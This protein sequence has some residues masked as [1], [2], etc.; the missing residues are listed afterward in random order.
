M[1][2]KG[3]IK[4]AHCRI[5][6]C[7]NPPHVYPSGARAAYC[8]D[9]IRLRKGKSRGKENVTYP[10]ECVLRRLRTA[11]EQ[12]RPFLLL[13]PQA[14]ADLDERT[15]NT[16]EDRD[17]IVAGDRYQPYYRI[18]KRGLNIL[19]KCDV[20]VRRRDGICFKCGE[21]PRHV[22]G[23]GKTE[24][25][26]YECERARC[27]EKQARLRRIPPTKPCR[28]CK[29]APR[30]QYQPSGAWSNFC[31]D[32]DRMLRKRRKHTSSRELRELIRQGLR[33]V[34]TCPRC[35]ERPCVLHPNSVA[36]VC[37]VCKPIVERRYKLIRIMAKYAPT[38]AAA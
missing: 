17:W 23:K 13:D 15:L 35:K 33:D 4:R 11:L 1:P 29:I 24:N 27:N 36:Y 30:H 34:P 18:T 8:K 12:D 2:A 32:C 16:L 20:Q 6:G 37:A 3:S 38:K 26:C 28:H 7:H 19:A 9:H 14:E 21:R 10:M 5:D 31:A 22:N 25:Y